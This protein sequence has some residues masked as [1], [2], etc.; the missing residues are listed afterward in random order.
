VRV[1]MP[2]SKEEKR[3][4][5]RKRRQDPKVRKKIKEY[6]RKRNQDPRAKEEKREYDRKYYHEN[7]EKLLKRTNA[8]FQ[9]NKKKMIRYRRDWGIA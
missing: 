6:A 4:Y 3:E 8:Y 2:Y 9:R 1:A 7:R 5:D